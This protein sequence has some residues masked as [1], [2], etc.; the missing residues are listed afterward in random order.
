MPTPDNPQPPRYV[1]PYT[2][3]GSW[4]R[5]YVWFPGITT[6]QSDIGEWKGDPVQYAA[7]LTWEQAKRE[8][9]RVMK[10]EAKLLR[11]YRARMRDAEPTEAVQPYVPE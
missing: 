2:D 10:H 4:P 6:T 5:I 8:V 11:E 9:E 7:A 3:D 1:V